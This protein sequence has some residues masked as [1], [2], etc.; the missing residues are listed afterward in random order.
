MVNFWATWCPPCRVEMPAIQSR[1]EMHQPEF[2]VLAVDLGESADVVSDFAKEFGLS[3]DPLLDEEGE[4][5]DLYQVRGQPTTFF[6]D[7]QGKVQ[8][9]HIGLM[10]E[11][12]LD[13][14][15]AQVGLE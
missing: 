8:V 5:H 14:Y 9:V 4:V 13:G 2:V 3:F 15:L 12:Q 7:A 1:Y 10:T 11:S 6:I